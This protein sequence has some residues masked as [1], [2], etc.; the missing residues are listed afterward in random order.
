MDIELTVNEQGNGKPILVLHGG[1]WWMGGGVCCFDLND[2]FCR[3][4]CVGLEAIVVNLDYRLAP[5]HPYPVQLDDARAALAWMAA[6]PAGLGIDADRLGV[7]GMSSGAN[8]AASTTRTLTETG[9]PQVKVHVLMM[10][11]LDMTACR[12]SSA[13]TNTVVTRCPSPSLVRRTPA[14]PR[15]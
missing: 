3:R 7:L 2:P 8:V 14:E 6:D 11:S 10:P 1:A 12:P 13:A 15:P 5:E 4:L 9:G